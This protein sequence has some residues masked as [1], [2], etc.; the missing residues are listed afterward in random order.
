MDDGSHLLSTKEAARRLGVKPET[1]YAY[2][3]RGLLEPRTRAG[4]RGS[5]FEPADV[6]RLAERGRSGGSGPRPAL[7]IESAVTLLED[8]RYHYRGFDPCALAGEHRFEAVAELLWTGTLPEALPNWQPDMAAVKIARR[9]LA[10]LPGGALPLDHMRVACAALGTSDRLRFDM[11]PEAVQATARRTIAG[12]VEAVSPLRAPRRSGDGSLAETLWRR[13]S[14]K[15]PTRERLA[16][17]ESALILLA[18]HEL[19]ASTF[20]VRVAAS[21]RADPDAALGVGLGVLSGAFHGGGSLYAEELL[22]EIDQQGSAE[23]VVGEWLRRGQRIPGFGHA[24]YER[25]DPRAAVLLERVRDASPGAGAVRAVDALLDVA[26]SRALPLVN[27]DLALAA[28]TQS[29]GML[30]GAGEAIF[31]VARSAGWI[32]HTLEEY[33][34]R[35]PLRL[36]AVYTGPRPS[37]D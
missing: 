1:L 34:S 12:M 3:S 13:L 23:E 25:E 17:L 2:V 22:A 36:R 32:A 26:R 33:R 4:R 5:F 19:A 30:R 35:S 11:R 21:F 31:A 10:A 15:R 6:A 27:V 9:M 20:A 8:D 24:V 16:A 37:A 14:P 7:R 18:D 28:L 29:F